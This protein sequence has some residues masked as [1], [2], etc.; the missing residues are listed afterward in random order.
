MAPLHVRITIRR[1]GVAAR[2][3]GFAVGRQP[4]AVQLEGPGA[5]GPQ[6][7]TLPWDEGAE[8]IL[9]DLAYPSAAR[10]ERAGA[11]MAGLIAKAGWPAVATAVQAS[12]DAGHAIA[13]SVHADAPEVL[14]LPWS[15]LPVG[16][17]R[18]QDLPRVQ[19]R[20]AWPG[21]APPP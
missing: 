18:L 21:G 5:T 8:K 20:R 2:P 4:Y 10:V 17:G 14:A 19:I 13:L 12:A 7:V 9:R 16:R 6:D 3:H 1:P 11:W 15:L